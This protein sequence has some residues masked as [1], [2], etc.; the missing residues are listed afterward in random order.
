MFQPQRV[1]VYPVRVLSFSKLV[2]AIL[3]GVLMCVCLV[4]IVI[5]IRMQG[6]LLLNTKFF[7]H[8]FI[9]FS[10]LCTPTSI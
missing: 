2:E 7:I 9:F 4:E 10:L 8:F 3:A 5:T 6:A 1:M